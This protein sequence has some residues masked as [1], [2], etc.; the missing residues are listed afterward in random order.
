[1]HI[2]LRLRQSPTLANLHDWN[3]WLAGLHAGQAVIVL[4]LSTTKTLPISVSFLTTDDLQTSVAGSPVLTSATHQLF[5]LNLAYLVAAFFLLSAIAHMLMATMYRERY[6]A[7]LRRN[8]NY[9]RWFEYALSAS[10]MLVG[11]AVLAG[12]QDAASLGMIFTLSAI[13]NL[14]GLVMERVNPAKPK[15]VV[16][17]SGYIVGCVAGMTPWL[18]IATYICASNVYGSGHVP[19]FVYWIFV[20]LFVFFSS[21]AVNM[22]LQYKRIGPWKDYLYGER[23][24]MIL[25]LVAKSLLAWQVFA[26]VLQP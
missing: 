26:G 12:V 18:A 2:P 17:W 21:F 11:I 22:Y 14:L 13:M 6:E 20:S 7:D 8:R 25:S 24:Y 19:S 5:E 10:T 3:L 23:V 9:L 1:M 4:L 15:T 16:D